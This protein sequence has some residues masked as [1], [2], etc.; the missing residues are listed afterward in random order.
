MRCADTKNNFSSQFYSFSHFLR[1]HRQLVRAS[2]IPS[3]PHSSTFPCLLL[4][5]TQ[6]T[7]TVAII[8]GVF[9]ICWG[10]FLIFTLLHLW[11]QNELRA[12]VDTVDH[13]ERGG[14]ES[15]GNFSQN[16]TL[17]ATGK[18]ANM[19]INIGTCCLIMLKRCVRG[20]SLLD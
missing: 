14:G 3:I 1:E 16:S 19:N 12:T 8:I 5:T 2:I 15:G 11:G 17:P 18:N 9:L 20:I 13:Y 10:P 6:A 7:I 4:I